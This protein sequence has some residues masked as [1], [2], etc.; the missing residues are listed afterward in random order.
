VD[1]NALVA[2]AKYCQ[3][4]NISKGGL[5][6]RYIGRNGKSN[7]PFELDVL[8]IQDSICFT[9]LKNVPFNIIWTSYVASKNSSNNLRTNLLGLQF[10]KMMPNQIAQL[11][12][13][14]QKCTIR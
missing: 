10:W 11:D 9:Y 6:F 2:K 7:E 8:F 14:I 1:G 12:R 4:I 3:F 5:A 13:F